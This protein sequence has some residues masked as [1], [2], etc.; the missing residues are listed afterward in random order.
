MGTPKERH[1]LEGP[2]ASTA[3][4]L[5]KRKVESR[6]AGGG[7][8][9]VKP[10]PSR[11]LPSVNCSS[12]R[13]CRALL[14]AREAMA[15]TVHNQTLGEEPKMDCFCPEQTLPILPRQ[16]PWHRG[17]TVT[18]KASLYSISVSPTSS[19]PTPPEKLQSKE[20]YT[21]SVSSLLSPTWLRNQTCP[22]S[23]HERCNQ[24]Y[25]STQ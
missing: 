7:V 11:R 6:K 9:K 5:L 25:S 16:M 4:S 1:L 15:A 17:V 2:G 3:L 22:G 19:R 10:G 23:Q 14:R 20:S 18:I 8:R 12:L 24:I 13:S 21:A